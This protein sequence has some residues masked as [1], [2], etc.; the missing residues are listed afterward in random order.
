MATVLEVVAEEGQHVH[1]GEIAVLLE[2]MKT[3]IPV[4]AESSGLLRSLTVGQGDAVAER[5]VLAITE[6]RRF[7]AHGEAT[8]D[9]TAKAGTRR[10]LRPG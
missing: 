4:L 1:R 9:L 5:D 3:K 7:A 10:R 6:S 8:S 2:S